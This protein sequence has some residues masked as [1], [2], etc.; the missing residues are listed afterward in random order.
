M[1]TSEAPPAAY[2]QARKGGRDQETAEPLALRAPTGGGESLASAGVSWT[3]PA[4]QL[5]REIARQA[6]RSGGDEGRALPYASLRAAVIVSVP[7]AAYVETDLG[8]PWKGR[9]DGVRPF[10]V[11]DCTPSALAAQVGGAASLWGGMTLRGWA[12]RTKVDEAVVDA[13]LEAVDG[14][15]ALAESGGTATLD[16]LLA[17]DAPFRQAANAILQVVG[18]RL[19][20]QELFDGLGPVF[21]V[22]RGRSD[23]RAVE[24]ETW[25][26]PGNGGL[27]SMVARVSVETQPWMQGRILTVEATRRRWMGRLPTAAQLRGQRR[28]GCHLMGVG[29]S[30]VAISVDC[31]VRKG[32]IAFPATPAFMEQAI[33]VQADLAL[34]SIGEMV[35]RGPAEGVFMGLPYTTRFGRHPVKAGASSTDQLDLF[36]KV[37]EALSGMGFGPLA[38]TRVRFKVPG[39]EE[40]HAGIDLA[41]VVTDMAQSL[42][43]NELSPQALQDARARLT[44]SQ[45]DEGEIPEGALAAG[46]AR[47]AAIRSANEARLKNVHPGGP[48]SLVV[49]AR[50]EK[51]RTTLSALA[52]ALFGR[53]RVEARA[54]P[55]GTHGLRDTL[56]CPA[57]KARPRFEARVRAWAP[58]MRDVEALPRCHVLVQAAEEY[59]G[60]RE[61]GVNKMAGRY[62]LASGGNAAV[63]YLRPP[64]GGADSLA[65]YLHRVQAALNDLLF[66]HSGSVARV[67]EAVAA[68]FPDK[69]TRPTSLIG[70]SVVTQSRL[71]S[72][73]MGGKVC[74]ATRIDVAS[75]QTLG[76][77]GWF[78]ACMRWSPRWLPPTELLQEV[79]R[80]SATGLGPDRAAEKNSYQQFVRSMLDEALAAGERPLVLVN[81]T[82]A[83]SL[84][85]WLAD[86]DAASSTVSLAQEEFA[87]RS[88]WPNMRVVRVRTGVAARVIVRKTRD[89]EEL[90]A[91]T[92]RPTG[93]SVARPT[94]TM[95][96]GA[97]RVG[98][99]PHYWC[100]HG[101]FQVTFP[102]GLSV[103]RPMP[104]FRKVAKD[105]PAWHRAA[106]GSLTVSV[107]RDP[108]HREN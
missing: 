93:R 82:S 44:D 49:V 97:Y 91:V 89:Y 102:R 17:P 68:C 83:S 22:V 57:E 58:L 20:G 9:T 60:R 42:G 98:P 36:D 78:D 23:G 1:T 15:E 21:R 13:L 55:P 38:A 74:L 11:A 108:L 104:T 31:T 46:R 28:V 75:G 84:W 40:Y 2:W 34:G 66:G 33:R 7:E 37:A 14:G 99:H 86:K 106:A 103:Y 51:E 76:R 107:D 8:G 6:S 73:A 26:A 77:V 35:L 30:P 72:G 96:G 70:L 61:D 4:V 80:L 88:R 54:L 65:N 64:E 67:D 29:K 45:K 41:T 81:S 16:S 47:L 43:H 90:D 87:P 101:Y 18:R 52:Q 79:A 62:A 95:S 56:E 100:S 3:P 69:A 27:F 48:P 71:R 10:V 105:A 5:F 63:Q 94:T 39:R 92:G 12:E 50:T 59:D 53:I 85:P 19:E 25:P 24:F 32:E